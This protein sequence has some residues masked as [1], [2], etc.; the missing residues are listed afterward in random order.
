MAWLFVHSLFSHCGVY[1]N[2]MEL[3]ISLELLKA[4]YWM[5]LWLP[6]LVSVGF[7]MVTGKKPSKK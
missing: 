4:M 5:P 2:F 7:G 3:T 1:F 6:V